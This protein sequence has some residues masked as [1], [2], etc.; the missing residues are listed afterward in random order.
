MID[1]TASDMS[2]PW[3]A[4]VCAEA[5][6]YGVTPV[7]TFDKQL[8]WKAHII[9][10]SEPDRSEPHAMVLCL[11]FLGCTGYL[12]SGSDLKEVIWFH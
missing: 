4:C 1:I 12:M 2:Q 8:W 6:S 10:A 11:S 5:K 9:L 3:N 7:L